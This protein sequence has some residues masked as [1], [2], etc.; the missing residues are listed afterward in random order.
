M[1]AVGDGSS[2]EVVQDGTS[3]G[4]EIYAGTGSGRTTV[5]GLTHH[6]TTVRPVRHNCDVS[7]AP[8][9][10]TAKTPHPWDVLRRRD[11]R[12]LVAPQAVGKELPLFL[13][14][15][16]VK[17]IKYRCWENLL[18]PLLIPCIFHT[19][20]VKRDFTV[21]IVINVQVQKD[22]YIEKGYIDFFIISVYIPPLPY[23]PSSSYV[24]YKNVKDDLLFSK[25]MDL[26]E[27]LKNFE[28]VIFTLKEMTKESRKSF[29]SLKKHDTKHNLNVITTFYV[30]YDHV[31]I[32]FK[33]TN[34]FR[35]TKRFQ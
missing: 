18:S 16:V 7:R 11:S 26:V 3:E 14:G 28:Y 2:E 25:V 34:A 9:T 13:R 32:V 15:S 10:E 20:I 23:L 24:E 21:T 4:L 1:S 6:P 29:E 22:T 33:F 31:Q 30:L 5:H 17:P 19:Y 35:R 8:T 27:Q 12:T